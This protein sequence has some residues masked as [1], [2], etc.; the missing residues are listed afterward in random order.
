MVARKNTK[1]NDK[2]KTSVRFLYVLWKN[3]QRTRFGLQPMLEYIVKKGKEMIDRINFIFE[4]KR[5]DKKMR[6]RSR[7]MEILQ[8][9][10][11]ARKKNFQKCGWTNGSI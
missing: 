11:K 5:E 3:L 1:R 6:E 2:G 8:D 7:D 10:I 9:Y 4:L